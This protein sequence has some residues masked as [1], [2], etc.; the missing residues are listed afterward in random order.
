MPK[1]MNIDIY[2]VWSHD[3]FFFLKIMVCVFSGVVWTPKYL[4]NVSDR[5]K[6]QEPVAVAEALVLLPCFLHQF[7]SNLLH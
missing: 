3:R 7:G 1:T 2:R 6:L 5:L 4:F